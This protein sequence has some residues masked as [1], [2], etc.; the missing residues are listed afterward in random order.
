ML[1]FMR[2]LALALMVSGGIASEGSADCTYRTR[3]PSGATFSGWAQETS[4]ACVVS[5]DPG[6]PRCRPGF[7]HQCL[8]G[9]W[10]PLGAAPC[11]EPL[12]AAPPQ[13]SGRADARLV[14]PGNDTSVNGCLYYDRDGRRFDLPPA[15]LAWAE[16]SGLVARK[17]CPPYASREIR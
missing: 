7:L 6:C 1:R 10:I 11:E 15:D 9:S 4:L 16:Q 3:A 8:G 12:T 14:Q 17:S 2:Y 5:V 13:I